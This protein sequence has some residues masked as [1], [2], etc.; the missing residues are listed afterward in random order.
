LLQVCPGLWEGGLVLLLGLPRGHPPWGC[1]LPT[2]GAHMGL[3]LLFSETKKVLGP[4]GAEAPVWASPIL[5]PWA[6]ALPLRL[7]PPFPG[8]GLA[9]SRTFLGEF[10]PLLQSPPSHLPHSSHPLDRPPP[11]RV[12]HQSGSAVLRIRAAFPLPWELSGPR[13]HT[14]PAGSLPARHDPSPSPLAY[15]CRIHVSWVV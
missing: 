11:V 10:F 7:P 3:P 6:Q 8:T 14:F 5:D 12:R 13:S 4:F 9:G 15:P 2:R 1:S